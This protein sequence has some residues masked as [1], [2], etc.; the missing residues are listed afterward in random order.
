MIA[1]YDRCFRYPGRAALN[2][3]RPAAASCLP[4]DDG[5]VVTP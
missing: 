2:P 3:L 5:D 4:I 1:E